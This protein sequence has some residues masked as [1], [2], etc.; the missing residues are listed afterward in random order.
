MN[1]KKKIVCILLAVAL[2]ILL[3]VGGLLVWQWNNIQAVISF[4]RFSQEEL[5]EKL[6][7]KDQAIKDA[8]DSIPNLTIRD[9]TQEEKDALKEGTLTPEELVQNLTQSDPKPEQQ[10]QIKPEQPQQEEKPPATLPEQSKEDPPQ[11]PDYDQRL[12][13]L[14]AQVYVLREEFLGK[15]DDLQAEATVAYLAIPVN[16][17][18]T[19]T[20]AN[21]VGEYMSKGLDMEKECDAQ[22]EQIV[23]EMETLLKENGGDM[24]IA[25]TVYDTYVEEKSLKKAWYMAELKKRGM[26]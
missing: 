3:C 21:L 13:E 15:L 4:A 18:T 14:I 1:R 7:E 24:S 16:E 26:M 23:V 25:Q 19:K 12:S 6:L 10:P 8:V 11:Q 2:A 20:V 22:I 17:R 9:I 5:E